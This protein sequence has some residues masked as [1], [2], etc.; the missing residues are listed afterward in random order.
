M[1]SSNEL[2]LVT[3]GS[4][5]QG[6][7]CIIAALQ[8]GY[9]VRTTV[10]SL[11]KADDVR[12]SLESG[13]ATKEQ[14]REVEFVAADLLKDDGWQ[15]A[16]EGATYVLHVAS[17]FPPLVP[18]DE[19][20]LIV[21]AREGTLRALRAAKASGTVR[22]VVITS[23]YAA[24]GYGHPYPEKT[25]FTEEDWTILDNPAA[26][27]P[28]YPKSK[29]LAEQAAWQFVKDEGGIELATVNP[30]GIYGPILSKNYSTS[31]E[32]VVRCMNGQM[33][34]VPDLT[35]G[36]VDARDVA[37]LHIRAMVDPKAAGQRFLATASDF[38]SVQEIALTLRERLGDKARRVPTRIAPNL[39]LKVMAFFDP[40]VAMVVPDLGKKTT[41]SN[42]KA[43]TVLGWQPRSAADSL[44]ATAES[45]EKFGLLKK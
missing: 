27:V 18:K 37:D 16:C 14:T 15:E 36:V 38:L 24:V 8:H 41:C 33:P 20:E 10:R 23:S 13:G 32:L 1:A 35:F 31:V 17:P 3:G 43:M 44:V 25:K 6:G 28:A 4:G 22:R 19:S 21:P 11:K 40:T 34:A 45:L 9:R 2:V 12:R 30:V 39:L 29:T 26:H 5:F 42:E 7:H